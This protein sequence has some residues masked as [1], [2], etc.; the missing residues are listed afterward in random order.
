MTV[1]IKDETDM[2]CDGFTF[3]A[4]AAKTTTTKSV[5]I[6][7]MGKTG[8][9]GKRNGTT[10][11]PTANDADDAE[12]AWINAKLDKAKTGETVGVG[13]YSRGQ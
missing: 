12:L 1:S 2:D 9:G 7:K 5:P 3:L 4:S 8:K 13:E 6:S 10:I 11:K